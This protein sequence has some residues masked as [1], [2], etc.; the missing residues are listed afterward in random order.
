MSPLRRNFLQIMVVTVFV[1]LPPLLSLP[2]ILT[3]G[4]RL[5]AAALAIIFVMKS[6]SCFN[7]ME[8][9]SANLK[10]GTFLFG[11]FIGVGILGLS[12]ILLEPLLIPIEQPAN[13]QMLK[14]NT[15]VLVSLLA[16][17]LLFSGIV[18]EVVFRGFLQERLLQVTRVPWLSWLI[19]TVL[20][21]C[22]S[23]SQGLGYGAIG[24]VTGG[25]LG[26]VYQYRK[27]LL[28]VIIAHAVADGIYFVL[29]YSDTVS[30]LPVVK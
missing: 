1:L 5:V 11:A 25:I 3:M 17:V 2:T 26:A 27:N 21:A 16:S 6:P 14:G 18:E 10:K 20:F 23:V 22:M 7:W 19:T 15:G 24:L 4:G 28:L 12:N 13:M 9:L 8:Q 30:L 29:V